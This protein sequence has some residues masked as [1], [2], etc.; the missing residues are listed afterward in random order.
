MMLDWLGQAQA[1]T[2]IRRA[3]ENALETGHTT[4]DLGGR[5]STEEAG[6]H[7]AQWISAASK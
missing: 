4:R 2:L 3:V 1:A 7:I 5:L 6:R